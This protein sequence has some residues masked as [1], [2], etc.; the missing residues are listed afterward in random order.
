MLAYDLVE[1]HAV[2]SANSIR[3]LS[4]CVDDV[5]HIQKF[6]V[7]DDAVVSI[8]CR[9]QFIEVTSCLYLIA[10]ERYDIG[11]LTVYIAEFPPERS[12]GILLADVLYSTPA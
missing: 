2:R 10:K 8:E 12:A 11:E 1:H 3:S 9:L 7:G 6:S 5:S 4:R